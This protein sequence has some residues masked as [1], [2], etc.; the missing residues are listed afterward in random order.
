MKFNAVNICPKLDSGLCNQFYA[1][2][3]CIC[4]CINN[5]VNILFINKF[6]KSINTNNYCNIDEVININKLNNYLSQH[7]VFIVDSQNFI[8]NIESAYVI[9]NNIRL[10]DVT[11][12]IQMFAIN[13]ELVI[14]KDKE[15][16]KSKLDVNKEYLLTVK[17]NLNNGYFEEKYII[18]NN[19]LITEIN[20]NFKHLDFNIYSVVGM[21]DKIF[22]DILQNIEFCDDFVIKADNIK[23]NIKKFNYN[24]INCIHLRLEDDFI[25]H[26]SENLQMD[27]SEIKRKLEKYY[28]HSIKKTIL[29]SDLTLILT[30]DMNNDVIKFLLDNNYKIITT[31]KIYKDREFNAIIDL[32]VG[33]LC[34]NVYLFVYESSFSYFFLIKKQKNYSP[35]IKIKLCELSFVMYL[36][37]EIQLE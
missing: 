15:L 27:K 5:D 14:S 6:Y 32:E 10:H 4:D 3:T 28:I 34:N 21:K 37:G 17:Y 19:K 2:V 7:K 24:K 16:F 35:D 11:E 22:W 26:Y 9:D 36:Q 31:E 30:N 23:N 13:N 29:P 12:D 25:K 18:K 33:Q 8:F 20:Y 1:L